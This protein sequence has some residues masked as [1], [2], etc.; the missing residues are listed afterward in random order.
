MDIKSCPLNLGHTYDS[1][2]PEI[3]PTHVFQKD[4]G[5]RWHGEFSSNYIEEVTHKTGNFKKFSVFVKMLGTSLK[6]VSMFFIFLNRSL[7]STM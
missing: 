7:C 5:S 3:L 4:D 1:R 6:Q 2:Q